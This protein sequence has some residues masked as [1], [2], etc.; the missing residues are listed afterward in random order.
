MRLRVT[1]WAMLACLVF[2][3]SGAFA[4]DI[5]GEIVGR[6]TD[7]SEAVLPGVSVTLT[8]PTLLQPLSTT[9]SETGSFRFSKVPIGAYMLRFELTGFTTV[10]RENIRITSGFTA[11]VNVSLSVSTVQE[12]VQVTSESPVVDTKKTG[13][14][15]TFTREVLEA[16]PTSRDPWVMMEQ[17]PSIVMDRAN[18]GGSQ[19]GQQS[20]FVVR[21]AG[22][23]NNVWS[24]DGVNV[25]DMSAVGATTMYYN[26]DNFEEMQYNIGGNDVSIATGGM[27]I[28]LVTKS[29]GDKFRGSGRYLITD[30]ALQGDNVTDALRAQGASAGNPIQRNLDSGVEIGGPILKSRAWFWGSVG[31]N[32]VKVGVNGFFK[33][34]AGCPTTSA[35]ARTVDTDKLRSCLSTDETLLKDYTFKLTGRTFKNNRLEWFS[36]YSDKYRN[37]RDA[38]A[39]RP[40]ETVVVQSGPVW[41]HKVND[42]EVFTDRWMG[43]FQY[44]FVGGGF[45]LDFPDPS[46]QFN[47]QRYYDE[48][49]GAYARSFSQSLF[50]RPL[51]LFDGKTTYFMPGVLGG[52]HAFKV[53]YSF[54]HAPVSSYGHIGGYVEDR[55]RSGVATTA[56]LYR[57]SFTS[58]VQNTQSAY[59]QDEYQAGRFTV[60]AGVRF[61]QYRD[62]AL[63][64]SVDANPIIPDLLPAVQFQG[65][66]SGVVWNNFSPRVGVNYDLFGTGKT[67]LG[68][69]VSRYYGQPAVGDLSA[70]LNPVGTVY[71]GYPWTDLN[72][73]QLVT[74][75][76]LNLSATPT[77]SGNYNPAAPGSPTTINSID[78]NL[79]NETTNEFIVGLQHEL[80]PGIALSA[81]YIYRKYDNFRWTT[82][83]GVTSDVYQ[84]VTATPTDC[85]ASNSVAGPCPTITYYKPTIAIG[86]RKLTY[87]NRPDYNRG[88]NG[89]ELSVTKRYSKRWFAN[90]SFA[91]NSAVDHYDSSRA[92][93][94]NNPATD[95][96]N[97]DKLNGFQWASESSGS[98][99]SNVWVNSKWVARASGS[100][101]LPFNVNVSGFLNG[102]QGYI[103]PYAYTTADRGNGASTVNV[104]LDPYGE[105]RLPNFW[106]FDFKVERPVQVGHLRLR[107]QLTV[108]NVTNSNLILARQRAINTSSYNDVL[109]I[110]GPRVM[111]VGIRAEF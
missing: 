78:P 90:A 23:A 14:T 45:A 63:A 50:N 88:Y 5:T 18:V 34:D 97:I 55:F 37:A 77:I 33:K 94:S 95:P 98:G 62:K 102:H 109:Q 70:T 17:T 6:V 106:Q 72:G 9:S 89:F 20:G 4:Q 12:V 64:S 103:L 43:E 67:V 85:F 8:G 87:T 91:Y 42:Q 2:G 53:G 66:D 83:E 92:Y 40:P 7:S 47:I 16:I 84:Q 24:L 69:T 52:D 107:P 48:V 26:F 31:R 29:G 68:L 19:S 79:K 44:A 22:T 96:T 51:Y 99:V 38:S 105:S 101:T 110:L 36:D 10:A 32:D 1:L 82:A 56:R 11:Q 61:D 30:N 54:R 73:D 58:Y 25:T 100:Y 111:Q 81:N 86:G 46:T 39:L 71:L 35:Q 21:G 104:I 41:T 49:S 75:N 28:N 59:A 76:E 57:D 3:A 60:R 15:A 93:T 74:R 27:G 65:A 13:S 80:F 108:F